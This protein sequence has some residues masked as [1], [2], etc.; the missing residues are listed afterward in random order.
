MKF[1]I[2]LLLLMSSCGT[3]KSNNVNVIDQNNIFEMTVDKY[4]QMLMN[5]NNKQGY[6]DIDK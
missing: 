1:L 2:I 4:K 5:Y 3:N 6:P